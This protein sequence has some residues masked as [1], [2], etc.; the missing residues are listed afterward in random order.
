MTIA[1]T[2]STLLV[3]VIVVVPTLNLLLL[4]RPSAAAAA[5]RRILHQPLFP[6]EWTPPPPENRQVPPATYGQPSSPTVPSQLVPT[7]IVGVSVAV[8]AVAVL[9]LSAFFLYTRKARPRDGT[10]MLAGEGDHNSDVPPPVVCAAV[11]SDPFYLGTFEPSPRRGS[12]EV[13]GSP[14]LRLKTE[15]QPSPQLQPLPS[16]DPTSSGTEVFRAQR[17]STTSIAIDSPWDTSF[18]KSQKELEDCR[19]ES[20][21]CSPITS[22]GKRLSSY[23]PCEVKRVFLP[24]SRPPPPPPPPPLLSPCP[25]HCDVPS[26]EEPSTPAPARRPFRRQWS[27]PASPADVPIPR[28]PPPPPLPTRSSPSPPQPP[29][30]GGQAGDRHSDVPPSEAASLPAPARPSARRRWAKPTSPDDILVP[31]AET[32]SNGDARASS[33]DGDRGDDDV[34]NS[35]KP[36]LKSLHWDKVRTTSDRAMIWDK[37]K[38]SSFQLNEEA[39]ET[40]FCNSASV[41][42]GEGNRGRARP[43]P[44]QENRLLD[45]KK[46]QNME[47]LLKAFNVTGEEVS[48]ALLDG[49][50]EELGVEL[51]EA[52]MKM[53]PTEQEELALRNYAGDPS[54]LGSAERFLKALLDIPHAYRRID[55]M[56][57]RSNFES[58]V[59]Y[60]RE[61]FESLEVACEELKKS[62][63]LLKLLDAVLRTGNRMN[64]GTARGQA[65]AFK[66]DTLLKLADVKGADR[67]MTL[68]HFVVREI[69]RSECE[70]PNGSWK[71]DD[72]GLKLV[73]GLGKELGNVKKA[74]GMD[75]DVLGRYLSN[76]EQGLEKIRMALQLGGAGPWAK[77][78][79]AMEAFQ[80]NAK[81][82]IARIKAAEKRALTL[83]REVTEYFH[84]DAAEEEAHPLRIFSVVGDFLSLLERVCKEVEKTRLPGRTI[85][86]SA[87]PFRMP[88]ALDR[89]VDEKDD[90]SNESPSS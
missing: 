50:P 77:F 61:S 56:L 32:E 63:L 9:S 59:K 6:I 88:P 44:K 8:A 62:S 48:E 75:S 40:L 2:L 36:S 26:S 53:E 85:I 81:E 78:S 15:Q 84:G 58:E 20:A 27:K 69:I 7:I 66:L 29:M 46:S 5:D 70:T 49:N 82:E 24:P 33:Q 41:A 35:R 64:V 87:Q 25:S 90:S 71:R 21:P 55:A 30:P 72:E 34:G 38:S 31:L 83:V 39:F 76:L 45:P 12:M 57:Y 43:S 14:Y 47:I 17:R 13:N 86:G 60:L 16:V 3:V 54:K 73:V 42:S 11:A 28:P 89:P 52:L 10:K 80:K 1:P 19:V 22:S 68:L 18:R 51:L 37:L 79:E 65:R 23:T 74:A 4:V 67:T